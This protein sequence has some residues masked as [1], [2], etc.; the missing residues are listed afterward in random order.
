LARRRSNCFD[1][2]FFWFLRLAIT[3][4][5]AFGHDILLAMLAWVMMVRAFSLNRMVQ[6]SG[7]PKRTGL[8]D[9]GKKR[10]SR[11]QR[12][13]RVRKPIRAVIRELCTR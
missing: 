8:M 5:F 3:F 13:N 1:L 12:G 10:Q 2:F 11:R 6:T 7:P 4:L 9:S